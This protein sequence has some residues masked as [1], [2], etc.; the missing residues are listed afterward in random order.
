MCKSCG[1]R[2]LN[3]RFRKDDN[4]GNYTC[5]TGNLWSVLDYILAEIS[6][7]DRIVDFEV[8]KRLES[9]HMPVCLSLAFLNIRF[10]CRA[11]KSA[12]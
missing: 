9:I 3:G 7:F 11:T 6:L 4:I 12:S 10:V 8:N 2:L 5:I 1:L